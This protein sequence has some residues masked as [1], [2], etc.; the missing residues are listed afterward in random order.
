M[1][2][3]ILFIGICLL[4]GIYYLEIK[5]LILRRAKI[6]YFRNG[7]NIP[8]NAYYH[9][10]SILWL[11]EYIVG[12]IGSCIFV[13][14]GMQGLGHSDRMLMLPDVSS[15]IH[16]NSSLL[17][18][19]MNKLKHRQLCI[20]L[21]PACYNYRNRTT[22]SNLIKIFTPVRFYHLGSQFCSDATA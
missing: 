14:N 13:N 18:T 5:V 21:R 20:K 6:N 8:T 15:K 22:L 1:G 2:C 19:I 11:I 3:S 17:H 12:L 7:Q 4:F 16:T 9:L 10:L